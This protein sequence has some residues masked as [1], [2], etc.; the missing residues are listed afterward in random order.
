MMWFDKRDARALFIDKR[1]E[2][3]AIDIG[4]PGT[5]EMKLLNHLIGAILLVSIVCIGC[6]LPPMWR[7][8]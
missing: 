7:W 6:G 1:R 4:T 2:S 5:R 8:R 3:H